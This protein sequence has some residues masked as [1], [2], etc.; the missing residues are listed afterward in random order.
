MLEIRYLRSTGQV[1]A[2][3]GDEMQFGNLDR[4]RD[5]EDILITLDAVPDVSIDRCLMKDGNLVI[6][7]EPILS[8]VLTPLERTIIKLV[9]KGVLTATEA[10]EINR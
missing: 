6:L 10:E 5:D 4:I 3:C 1:T 7:P 2:W 9:E 8:L